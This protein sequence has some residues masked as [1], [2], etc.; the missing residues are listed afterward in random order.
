M[1]VLGC[2]CRGGLEGCGR[3]AA[4]DNGGHIC[5]HFGECL[6]RHVGDVFSVTE[7]FSVGHF[8]ATGGVR[9]SHSSRGV[10]LVKV[11]TTIGC[12]NMKRTQSQKKIH[13]VAYIGVVEGNLECRLGRITA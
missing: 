4:F 1:F 8:D 10:F 13:I 5:D 2:S 9:S 7:E 11:R 3:V 12:I 6:A